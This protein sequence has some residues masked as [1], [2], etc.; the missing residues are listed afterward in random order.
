MTYAQPGYRWDHFVVLDVE[1]IVPGAAAEEG[2]PPWPRH[3]IVCTSM[4]LAD[5]QRYAEWNFDLVTVTGDSEDAIRTIDQLIGK[6][7]VCT[8][9]GRAFDAPCLGMAAMRC[10]AFD[11][12]NIARFWSSPR[13]GPAHADLVELYGNFGAARGGCSM[14]ELSGALDVPAKVNCDGGDV[15]AMVAAGEIDAVR[16]YCE[17]DT[18]ST[19]HLWANWAALRQDDPAYH[20]TILDQFAEYVREAGHNHLTEF[21]ELPRAEELRRRSVQAIASAGATAV[22]LREHLAWVDPERCARV[23]DPAFEDFDA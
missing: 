6:R 20:A 16:Q 9:N 1:T 5:R 23:V 19:L 21:L 3:E 12:H 14:K 22:E 15:A 2:F 11:C 18:A 7:T 17:A 10:H 13:F 8:L 4:L